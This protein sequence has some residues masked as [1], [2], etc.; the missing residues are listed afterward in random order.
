MSGVLDAG[1]GWP[2]APSQ[3]EPENLRSPSFCFRWQ[4]GS[5]DL[6][7]EVTQK[8]E[9]HGTRPDGPFSNEPDFSCNPY[10]NGLSDQVGWAARVQFSH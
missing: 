4:E 7:I 1:K 3:Q 2:N 5:F 9:F 10:R 8:S 6:S